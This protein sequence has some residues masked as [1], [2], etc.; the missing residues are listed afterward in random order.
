MT[1][2]E[3]TAMKLKVE[4][5][6]SMQLPGQPLGMHMG[7]YYLMAQMWK[8]INDMRSISKDAA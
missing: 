6:Q 5:F 3:F 7:T 8:T 2:H 4:Q 1:D